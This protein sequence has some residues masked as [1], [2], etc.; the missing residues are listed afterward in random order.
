MILELE[1]VHAHYGKSHVLQGVSLQVND[2][3]LVTLLGR[4]GAGK[5][6]TLKTIV[7]V[8]PPTQGNVNFCKNAING[9]PAHVIAKRGICL[10]PEHRG[11]FKL[12]TVEERSRSL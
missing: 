6:T 12:L 7:G 4:N 5:T 8:V 9:Q 11:I 1:N 10:V 3:E 2:G